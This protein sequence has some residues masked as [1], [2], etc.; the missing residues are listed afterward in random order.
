MTTFWVGGDGEGLKSE[1]YIQ[2]EPADY[3]EVGSG[4]AECIN[5]QA[6]KI[7]GSEGLQTA[8][9]MGCHVTEALLF[10]TSETRLAID[11]VH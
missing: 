11:T 10:S 5:G 8:N 3:Q 6:A 4:R 2:R 1:G 9:H 7:S